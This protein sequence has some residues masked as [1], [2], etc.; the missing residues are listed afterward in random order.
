MSGGKTFYLE[1]L[2]CAKNQVDGEAMVSRL[3]ELGWREEPDPAEASCIIVNT[4]GF[5]ERRKRNRS[6]QS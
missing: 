3:L 1:N 6:T 4:S 5:I 2:G